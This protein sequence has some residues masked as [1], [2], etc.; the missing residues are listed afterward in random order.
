MIDEIE[1]EIFGPG[2]TITA[3]ASF[4]EGEMKF[5][6]DVKKSTTS[7]Y[8]QLNYDESV[9]GTSGHNYHV[10]EYPLGY[11]EEEDDICD[12]TG[13]HFDPFGVGIDSCT[14]DYEDW[15]M[16]EIGDLSGK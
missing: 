2:S 11:L 5:V 13:A 9:G 10:H 1:K 12:T 15:K 7:V 6:Y 3:M 8:G 14:T 4:N 16:C